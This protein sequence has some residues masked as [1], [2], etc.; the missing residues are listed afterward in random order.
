M[1]L[2][3]DVLFLQENATVLILTSHHE[4]GFRPWAGMWWV[5]CLVFCVA[6]IWIHLYCQICPQL[7]HDKKTPLPFVLFRACGKWVETFFKC[8]HSLFLLHFIPSSFP[9]SIRR[10][11]CVEE[12]EAFW[13]HSDSLDLPYSFIS[14]TS[15]PLKPF[16]FCFL[17]IACMFTISCR[18]KW[19]WFQSI[20]FSLSSP[21]LAPDGGIS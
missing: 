3:K 7:L 2:P 9:K 15:M 14:F 10:C 21:L 1:R 16:P 6:I 19:W 12:R 20:V 13:N 8:P 4:L 5:W 11:L 17:I 18:V